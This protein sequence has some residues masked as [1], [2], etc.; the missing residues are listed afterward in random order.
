MSVRFSC[1]IILFKSIFLLIFCMITVSIV[2][3]GLLKILTTISIYL[4]I[5]I[6]EVS[7]YYLYLAGLLLSV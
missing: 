2:E 6:Y 3:S 4:F 7:F 1:F 5:P